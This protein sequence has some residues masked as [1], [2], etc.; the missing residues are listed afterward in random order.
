MLAGSAAAPFFSSSCI[1]SRSHSE[2]SLVSF[3]S[4]FGSFC[5][6]T[7]ALAEEGFSM[8]G[9]GAWTITGAGACTIGAGACITGARGWTTVV[10]A[11]FGALA[12]TS[13]G[14]FLAGYFDITSS[15]FSYESAPTDSSAITIDFFSLWGAGASVE[16]FLFSYSESD[17]LR[18]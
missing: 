7:T 2:Y 1:S 11:G 5:S 15:S 3:F 13:L 18:S 9:A 16:A 17:S 8:I 4:N 10:Y 14:P 6:G 12:L